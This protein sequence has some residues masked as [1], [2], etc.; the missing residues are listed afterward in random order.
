MRIELMIRLKVNQFGDT[1][2][3]NQFLEPKKQL[4]KV[5]FDDAK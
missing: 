3:T 4:V 1:F 2:Y 5:F